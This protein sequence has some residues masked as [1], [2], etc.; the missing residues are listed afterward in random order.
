MAD[1][2]TSIFYANE[3]TEVANGNTI[4]WN[5]EE[6]S[7]GNNVTLNDFAWS[8][9]YTESFYFTNYLYYKF[10]ETDISSFIDSNSNLIPTQI[11]INVKFAAYQTYASLL[12][13]LIPV[14]TSKNGVIIATPISSNETYSIP[15]NI[16]VNETSFVY[17]LSTGFPSTEELVDKDFN[18][19]F[20]VAVNNPTNDQS[21]A[22]IYEVAL[23]IT[24]ETPS[25]ALISVTSGEEELIQNGRV[26]DLG[27]I[28]YLGSLS[29][30]ILIDNLGETNLIIE[31]VYSNYS[32]NI[33]FEFSGNEFP[34]QILPSDEPFSINIKMLGFSV[35]SHNIA[36]TIK[37]DSEQYTEFTFYFLLSVLSSSSNSSIAV[38]N[39][40]ERINNNGSISVAAQPKDISKFVQ[41]TYYNTGTSPLLISSVFLS[42]NVS[43]FPGSTLLNNSIIQAGGS[44]VLNLSLDVS[45]YGNKLATITVNS[46]DPQN[47]PFIFNLSYTILPQFEAYLSSEG[48]I[49]SDGINVPLGFLDKGKSFIKTYSIKNTGIYKTLIVNSVSVSDEMLLNSSIL[50]PVTLSPNAAN[51]LV[52]AI[53]FDTDSVGL[54]NG[55]L[56]VDYSEGTVQ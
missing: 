33:D 34:V 5:T 32:E 27:S 41:I 43:S 53:T 45:S 44:A 50:F 6:Y 51:S 17:N 47:N 12:A 28:F 16:G 13:T 2:A 25:G 20:T 26:I 9:Y 15:G 14:I 4:T 38:Y 7:L 39:N 8:D 55:S 42:G 1:T 30:K 37:S 52:F 24:L 19:F 3:V 21:G 23:E 18:V 40:L 56:T 11:K 10:N 49:L 22:I 46:N 48:S 35:G 36:I 54:R 29:Y 31:S